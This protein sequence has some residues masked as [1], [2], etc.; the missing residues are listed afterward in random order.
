MDEGGEA[1]ILSAMA[2][3]AFKETCNHLSCQKGNSDHG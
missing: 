2:Q 3:Q 1:V